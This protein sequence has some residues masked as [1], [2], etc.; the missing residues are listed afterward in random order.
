[1]E[2][3]LADLLADLPVALDVRLSHVEVTPGWLE[4]RCAPRG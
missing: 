3:D 1:V 4:L 2:L